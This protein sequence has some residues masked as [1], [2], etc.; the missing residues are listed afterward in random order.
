MLV[1]STSDRSSVMRLT[2]VASCQSIICMPEKQNPITFV[3][4][5][6]ELNQ[7]CTVTCGHVEVTCFSW[8]DQI[9]KKRSVAMRRKLP[10]GLNKICLIGSSSFPFMIDFDI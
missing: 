1:R 10:V 6:G 3:A 7:R 9:F 4:S 5:N 2:K 8:V